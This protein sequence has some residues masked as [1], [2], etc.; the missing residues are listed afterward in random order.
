MRLTRR[1]LLTSAIASA[2]LLSTGLQADAYPDQPVTIVVS[3]P[4][5]AD[6]DA[7]A[8]LFAD[9]LTERLG[10]PVVVENRPGAG[11]TIGNGTVARTEADGYTLLYTPNPFTTA[12]L[13]MDLPEGASYDVLEGF[14]P[15][16]LAAHQ[17]VLVVAN[18]ETGIETIDDLVTQAHNGQNLSYG[19][20]GAGSPMHIAAEW[21]NREAEIEAL[22]IPYR[23]VSPIV[24]DVLAGHIDLGYVTYGPVAQLIESGRLNLVAI[25][26]PQRSPVL[27]GIPTIAEQGYDAVRLGAWHGL[28]APSGTPEEVI[29]TLN[30]QMNA[31]LEMPEVIEQMAQFGAVPAGGEPEALAEINADDYARLSAIIEE[32]GITAD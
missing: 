28:M 1:L 27:E 7:M 17:A 6:T 25:T 13:V 29:E 12:P 31:I 23:G 11:G 22:H 15:I 8:R 21:L 3:Y 2:A 9:K 24:P 16:I 30:A 5:G 18:P 20:P 32:L 26:D 10:Q 19:S 4:P 14:D